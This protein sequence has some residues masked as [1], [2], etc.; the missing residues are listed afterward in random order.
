[1]D[2]LRHLPG[3][4]TLL[5]T[6][7]MASVIDAHGIESVKD[8]LRRLQADWRGR[9]TPPPWAAEAQSWADAVARELGASEYRTVFNLSGTVLHSNLGRALPAPELFDAVRDLVTRPMNLEF[10]LTSGRRGD[11]EAPVARRLSLLTGAAAVTVVNNNAAALMLVLNTLARERTVPVSRGELVEIGGSFRLPELMARAGCRL[12]EVGTTNRTHPDDYRDS[13]AHAPALLLKVHPSNY[14]IR[15]FS[16]SVSVAELAD[17]AR[18]LEV[19]LIVDLGSGALVDLQRWGLPHEPT[20]AEVLA[21]GADLVTFSGDKLLGGVQAGLI[22]GR[23]DLVSACRRNPMKRALRADKITL[24][25]LDRTLALYEAPEQLAERLPLLHTLTM[26]LDRLNDRAGRVAALLG[27]QL[28]GWQ[29][30]R[31]PS[32]ALI[33][34]GALPETALDSIAVTVRH[35][36]PARTRALQARLRGLRVPVIAR[37]QHD[38]LWL[39]M[40]GAEPEDE[41]LDVLSGLTPA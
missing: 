11:R 15:G 10:E 20:P 18:G 37:L 9:G 33:G 28:P 32:E 14:Q 36:D 3:I 16:R 39:D 29:I 5:G 6:P 1:M 34:S 19:P 21:Q 38:R 8:A 13:A 26:P 24:A 17:I 25:L 41:L 31:A 2:P 30:E 35:D 4:D 23:S 40:R 7:P 27:R 12:L 22:V